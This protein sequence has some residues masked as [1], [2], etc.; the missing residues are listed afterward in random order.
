MSD[1]RIDELLNWV[2]ILG[3]APLRDLLTLHIRSETDL[4]AYEA[5]NGE[6]NRDQVG[7][8]AGLSG[9]AVG[10]RWASWKEA[11]IVVEHPDMKH[12]QRIAS[13]E[14]VGFELHA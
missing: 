11:G 5:T 10:N 13:A 12:P 2:R 4:A 9:R 8:R 7:K 6:R 1:N 14:S 3:A